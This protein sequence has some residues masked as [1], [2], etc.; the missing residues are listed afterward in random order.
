VSSRT[1][2]ATQRN[3]VLEKKLKIYIFFFSKVTTEFLEVPEARVLSFLF[4]F[5]YDGYIS[6]FPEVSTE[7]LEAPE[8]GFYPFCLY[9]APMSTSLFVSLK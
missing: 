6:F 1:A 7:L 8:E 5:C 3:P 4:I 2:R 9:N